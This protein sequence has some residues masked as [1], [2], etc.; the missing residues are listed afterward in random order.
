MDSDASDRN[1]HIQQDATGDRNQ[2]T[3]QVSGG[4]VINQLTIHERVPTALAPPPV[5]IVPPLTQQEYRQRQVLLNKVKDYW[6]EGVL[7]TSLHTRVMIELGL[8]ARP[9]LVQRPFQDMAEF[10]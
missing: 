1:L 8:H 7:K 6:I 9:D 4:I 10:P 3:G 2:V 5:A